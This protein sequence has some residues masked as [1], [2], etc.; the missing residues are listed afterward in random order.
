[1][2]LLV[3]GLD[4]VGNIKDMKSGNQQTIILTSDKVVYK[5]EH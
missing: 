4:N 3:Y 1:M 5:I 2:P